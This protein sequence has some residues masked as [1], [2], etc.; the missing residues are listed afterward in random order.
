MKKLSV[1]LLGVTLIWAF[2]CKGE[3][4]P[5]LP[6]KDGYVTVEEGIKLYYRTVGDGPETIIIPAGFYL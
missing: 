3:E 4:E 6:V 1:I 5:E 2:G